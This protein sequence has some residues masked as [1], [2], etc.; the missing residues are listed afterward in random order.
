ML[1]E[2]DPG[3]IMSRLQELDLNRFIYPPFAFDARQGEAL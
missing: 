1:L 2:A 3:A